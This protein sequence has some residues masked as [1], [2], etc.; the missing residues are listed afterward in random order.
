MFMVGHFFKIFL[1][2]TKHVCHNLY[3][4]SSFS[5]I[6]KQVSFC[7]K[8]H[9]EKMLRGLGTTAYQAHDILV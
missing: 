8:L 5:Q 1:Y 3:L 7:C 4:F 2:Y 6:R 9:D